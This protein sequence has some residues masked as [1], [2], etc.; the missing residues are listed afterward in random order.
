M[1]LRGM[2]LQNIKSNV[3]TTHKT[4]YSWVLDFAVVLYIACSGNDSTLQLRSSLPKSEERR[5][6]TE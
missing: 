1:N 5:T 2:K 3:L 4:V 6:R